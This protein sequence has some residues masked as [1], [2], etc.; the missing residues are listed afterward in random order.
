MRIAVLVKQ[1]P[2]P[3]DLALAGGRLVRAGLPSETSAYCR[4]ANARAVELAGPAG[5]VVV[6]TMG[7]PAAQDALREMIACGARRGVL[8]SDPALAGSDSLVTARVLAAAIRREGP[9][10]LVLTGAFSLDSETGHVGVQVAEILGLPF[11][12]PCRSLSLTDGVLVG[13]VEHEGGFLDVEV[14]LP[15]VASAAERLCAPSKAD[16]D[17]IGAVPAG[18]ISRVTAAGL[19][20]DPGEAGLAG[21]PTVVGERMRTVSVRERHRLRAA[22]AAEALDMLDDLAGA[23]GPPPAPPPPA[24]VSPGPASRAPVWCVL[25]PA[26]AEPDLGLIAAVTSVAAAAGRPVRAVVGTPGQLARSVAADVLAVSGPAAPEDW[27]AV[28][29]PRLAR[30]RPHAAVFECTGWGREVAARVAARL[31][32]GLVGDTVDLT[33]E[34]GRLVAWKSAFSGQA[35][36]P[37]SSRSPTLL[38]TARPGAITAPLPGA[39]ALASRVETV[40]SS[41]RTRVIYDSPLDVDR[42]G[43][44]LS[45]SARVV[46]VGTG[47]RPEHY[48]LVDELRTQL[49]AGP[50][51]ATRRVTDAGWLP[52]SRQIGITG[53]SVAPALLVSVGASGRFNHA[54]GFRG[55]SVVLAIN[56]D[57]DAE[58]FARADIGIV[59]DWRQVTAALV[60]ELRAREASLAGRAG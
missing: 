31:G 47:V 4:R 12:G 22:S 6:F 28:L 54:A 36:V 42:Q 32:W 16:R 40:H 10:D 27:A 24:A 8:V 7:P 20:L 52:R 55:A 2:R 23:G 41:S 19:G 39:S 50:L 33:I 38:L 43:R 18:L 3:A 58:I 30:Q 56:H 53:R 49:G 14:L 44:E 59:G 45:R 21:S 57:P 15:A 11:A 9:F 13:T 5:D 34:D 51:G 17:R 1:I 37:I 48:R 25:D 46:V 26:A 35:V 60:A 29:A